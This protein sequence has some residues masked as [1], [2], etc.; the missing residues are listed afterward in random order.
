MNLIVL[1]TETSDL[2]PEKGAK[3]LEIAWIELSHTGQAWERVHFSDFYIEQP[4]SLV[5]NP[6]AQA[7]HHIRADMLRPERGAKPRYEI[8]RTLLNQIEPSTI[9]VAHNAEFDSRFL[10]E[11]SGSPWICTFRAAKHIW[12]GAPG[13]SNQVLRYWLK[14]EP[15]LP[16]GKHPHQALYDVTVTVSILQKMLEQHTPDQLL[17]LSKLPV[18]MKTIGFGKHKGLDFNQLPPDYIA[19]LRRQPNLDADLVH[20][21]DSILKP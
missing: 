13:Y 3:L 11:I 19:W 5:I 10:P 2:D 14:L 9:L 1:D 4:T 6:H 8:I 7:T 20:T 12:P 15:D 21:L 16:F 17:K 18:R